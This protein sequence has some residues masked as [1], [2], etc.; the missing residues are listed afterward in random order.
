MPETNGTSD[1]ETD[2]LLEELNTETKEYLQQRRELVQ[3]AKTSTP[4]KEPFDINEFGK[5]YSLGRDSG[6]TN[7]SPELIESL[8]AEYYVDN[9]DINTLDDFATKKNESDK[10]F[11]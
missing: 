10:D 11:S 6:E 4:Q 7:I 9:P 5:R 1:S 8:E 2:L 3:Q